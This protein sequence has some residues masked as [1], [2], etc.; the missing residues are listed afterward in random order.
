[1]DLEV[2]AAWIALMLS[3]I[4]VVI[5]TLVA[6]RYADTHFTIT[7]ATIEIADAS[8]Q[9]VIEFAL[10]SA[11]QNLARNVRVSFVADPLG[12]ML[13][14]VPKAWKGVAAGE[15]VRFSL[16]NMR[17]FDA[18]DQR[19]RL[20]T[21]YIQSGVEGAADVVVSWSNPLGFRRKQVIRL[22]PLP[23]EAPWARDEMR[24]VARQ[25]RPFKI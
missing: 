13:Q 3:V 7:P 8:G 19:H 17:Y 2:L 1:M 22:Q 11:G 23:D 18:P 24:D 14:T 5:S 12:V 16:P 10:R 20:N 15:T 6:S 21:L 25:A 9:P 4:A